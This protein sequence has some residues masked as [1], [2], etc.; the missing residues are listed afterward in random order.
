MTQ[1]ASS[2]APVARPIYC[3]GDSHV[4][5]FSGTDRIQPIW[6]QPSADALPYFRTF[7]VGAALA[8]NLMRAGTKT[9]GREQVWEIL[10][11]AVPPSGRVLLC[12]GEIDCRAHLLHQAEQQQR[13]PAEI[14]RDCAARYFEAI[15]EIRAAGFEVIVYNAIPSRRKSGKAS[16][17]HDEFPTV[18]TCRERNAVSRNFN[19]ALATD[20]A[21]HSITFLS[22]FEFFVDTRGLTRGWFYLDRIHLSQRAM[23]ATLQVLRARFP[24]LQIPDQGNIAPPSSWQR[25]KDFAAKRRARI[26]RELGKAVS[27]IRG[28][29]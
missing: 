3:L 29:R 23:P 13:A 9:R 17:P 24:D 14:A 12:F 5:F 28:K 1:N 4:S 10:L 25:W 20:C 6:P 22:T 7:H 27:K 26:S 15:Q 18:G 19:D 16:D 8:F 11:T 2:G 21:K